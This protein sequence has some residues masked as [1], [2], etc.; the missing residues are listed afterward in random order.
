[1]TQVA[2]VIASGH[3]LNGLDALGT[4]VMVV[5]IAALV[6]VAVIVWALIA[7]SRSARTKPELPVLPRARAKRVDR[8]RTSERS[9]GVELRG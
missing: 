3:E 1:M 6:V 8:K 9:S 4:Y 2:Y 7:L 5:A